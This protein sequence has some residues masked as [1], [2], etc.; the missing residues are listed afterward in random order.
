MAID[1][2]I[3]TNAS[4]G[5]YDPVSLVRKAKDAGLTIISLTDHETTS[6]FTPAFN[7]GVKLGV[8]VIPAVELQT[9][10]NGLEIHLLG[11]LTDP[12]NKMLQQQLGELRNMR[13]NCSLTT[14]KKM[15]EF[16]FDITWQDVKNLA[17]S[18]SIVSKGHI[19]RAIRNAGYIRDRDDAFHIINT[20]LNQNGLAYVCHEFRFED[21]VRL[22]KDV[23]GIPV[24][25]HPALIN[26]EEVVEELCTKGVEGVEVYYFYFGSK[27]EEWVNRYSSLAEEKKLMKTGGSDFHGEYT[28]VVLGNTEVPFEEVKE[29]LKILGI[30]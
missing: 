1:L 2:H 12:D 20:Y 18:D 15:R 22:I 11:Y 14:V 7:E 25:A 23:G 4:D 13:T 3:H 10:Y 19:I 24:L 5:S 17:S 6:G 8:T 27:R 26:N 30:R 9:Y 29:L 28:P 16:G 21:A